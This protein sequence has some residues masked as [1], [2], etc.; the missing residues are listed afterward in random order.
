MFF[1]GS[2]QRHSRVVEL[3]H[4]WKVEGETLNCRKTLFQQLGLVATYLWRFLVYGKEKAGLGWAG[5]EEQEK[6]TW[7]LNLRIQII[8][9]IDKIEQDL[10]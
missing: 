8:D 4:W 5:L 2:V 9:F 10:A 6:S 1:C 3:E 7:P